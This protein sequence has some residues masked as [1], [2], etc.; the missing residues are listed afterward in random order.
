MYRGKGTKVGGTGKNQRKLIQRK[1][2]ETTISKKTKYK[3]EY[4]SCPQE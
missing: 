2:R 3:E 4:I 1:I